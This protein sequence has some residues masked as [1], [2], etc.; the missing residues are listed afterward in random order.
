MGESALHNAVRA[1]HG[2]VALLLLE[3]G[4]DPSLVC[5]RGASAEE[6][7]TPIQEVEQR[8]KK[9]RSSALQKLH[10]RM[11]EVV[12]AR[13]S[14]KALEW[15][16]ENQAAS[17]RQTRPLSPVKGFLASKT[18]GRSDE[19]RAAGLTLGGQRQSASLSNDVAKAGE[20]AARQRRAE[21]VKAPLAH[22]SG[23]GEGNLSQAKESLPE[24]IAVAP[25]V[26]CFEDLIG[27]AA[28][29]NKLVRKRAAK[30]YSVGTMSKKEKTCIA[31]IVMLVRRIS[32]QRGSF[33]SFKSMMEDSVR[34]HWNPIV[35]SRSSNVRWAAI[36]HHRMLQCGQLLQRDQM[37]DI[38][39]VLEFHQNMTRKKSLA[40]SRIDPSD[41]IP[42]RSASDIDQV[43]LEAILVNDMR[44]HL[45]SHSLD[46]DNS[47][48][49]LRP[50]AR[51][52]GNL[53]VDLASMHAACRTFDDL[54]NGPVEHKAAG[55]PL[56]SRGLT[57]SATT[58]GNIHY[59]SFPASAYPSL[60]KRDL[61][62]VFVEQLRFVDDNELLVKSRALIEILRHDRVHSRLWEE[63]QTLERG[64][65][66][67]AYT[68]RTS[69]SATS[70]FESFDSLGPV[71]GI[72][73]AANSGYSIMRYSGAYIEYWSLG[74]ETVSPTTPGAHRGCCLRLYSI[75]EEVAV[76][77]VDVRV[78]IPLPLIALQR[79]EKGQVSAME[80]LVDGPISASMRH[81]LSDMSSLHT[82]V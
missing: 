73:E 33:R 75:P 12:Q 14:G 8:L 32:C 67:I 70:S 37:Q 41:S 9:R 27:L 58:E 48:V 46:P 30:L 16:K 79:I 62:A 22:R 51:L 72:E 24:P 55:A 40:A 4:A 23:S 29:V 66:V 65:L 43:E 53:G 31:T 17:E 56:R 74:G 7:R 13:A 5:S 2:E 18:T 6:A 44:C 77:D 45:L 15:L 71:D 78:V 60:V 20:E 54:K 49:G 42:S 3:Y 26:E 57:L 36:F 52:V 80:D 61:P 34:V 47:L 28:N 82:T 50:S 59:A 81:V 68:P 39:D 76:C 69:A 25:L 19:Q 21:T 38:L 63:C 1:G 64:D 10:G 35:R 11:Q